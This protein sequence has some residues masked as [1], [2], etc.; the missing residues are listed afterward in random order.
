MAK[1]AESF[2]KS[3]MTTMEHSAIQTNPKIPQTA[4]LTASTPYRT[5]LSI[6]LNAIRDNV[7]TIKRHAKPPAEIMAVLKADACGL[8]AREIVN[9]VLAGGATSI[10]VA[11]AHEAAELRRTYTGPLLLLGSFLSAE[12]PLLVQTE[13]MLPVSTL[14]DLELLNQLAHKHG[15]RARVHLVIDSGMGRL[16][17][18]PAHAITL[19]TAALKLPHL[20]VEGCYSH[21]SNAFAPND[22]YTEMQLKTFDALRAKLLAHIE[23]TPALQTALG[24]RRLLFHMANSD[25]AHNYPASSYA[26][27]RS[28]I[29]LYG[30]T[31]PERSGHERYKL[32]PALQL[33]SKL[34]AIRKLP[35]GTGIGYGVSHRLAEEAY[36]GTV[37]AGYADGVPLGLSNCFHVMIKG[38][39][40]PIIGRISMDYLTVLLGKTVPTG[41][42]LGVPVTLFGTDGTASI[43][44]NAWAELKGTHAYDILTGIPARVARQYTALTNP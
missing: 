20:Q 28:G 33:R 38:K 27:I 19:L 10:A 25:G 5:V 4:I 23:R 34:L 41:I 18:L 40:Y 36:V 7:A 6:E 2:V 13:T 16:G 15:K 11:T 42:T 44:V 21:F 22:P 3:M 8:G 43:S 31:A 24:K 32:K 37:G 35:Q 12:A 14:A 9:A 29:N 1:L 17:A 30:L 26:L 39:R